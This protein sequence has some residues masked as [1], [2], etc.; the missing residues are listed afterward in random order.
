LA[1]ETGIG[2][3]GYGIG[4]VHAHAWKDIPLFYDN[5]D[6]KPKLAGFC[7]RDPTKSLE[8]KQNFGFGKT[9][10]DWRD[11]VRDPSIE[12][13]DNCA[14]PNLHLDTCVAAAESGKAMICEKPLARTKDEAFEVHQLTKSSGIPAMSG[15]TVRFA[16]AVL[17]A[18]NLI[19]SG[20]LGRILNFRCCYLSIESGLNGYWDPNYPLHWHF[21]KKIAGQGAIAD[22]GSHALDMAHFLLGDITEVCG[23]I[24]TVVPE[25][26]LAEGSNQKGKVTVDDVTVAALKFKSG[27]LGTIDASWMASG[28]K[29]FFYFEVFGSEGSLRF[30][31]E[32]MNELEVS[33]KDNSGFPGFKTV[34]TTSKDFPGMD[35]LWT[36]QGGGFT[37]NHLFVVELKYFLDWVV[38]GKPPDSIAPTFRDG[39]VNSLLI[40]SI[41]ES[42][43][44]GKWIK[45]EPRL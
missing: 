6:R 39:Y 18:K 43:E 24:Q 40:D 13:I 15:F 28:R 1:R 38:K 30:N 20:K 23:A 32:R 5:L 42:S 35:R 17:F 26:P 37:W 27:A 34:I 7:A 36:D 14:P 31:F 25:R 33:L 12:I 3:I 10:S 29:D 2:L 44:R 16:P 4:R 21:D 19:D 8:M 41:V 45:I 22:L 9:Y 11:L